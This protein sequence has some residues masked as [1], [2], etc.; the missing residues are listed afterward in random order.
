MRDRIWVDWH[1][2][3][4][5]IGLIGNKMDKI[6]KHP[7]HSAWHLCSELINSTTRTFHGANTFVLHMSNSAVDAD[8]FFSLRNL[9]GT[10]CRVQLLIA[11]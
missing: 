11:G 3:G 4:P 8:S 10:A 5:C 7:I 1:V 9:S 6:I 2:G